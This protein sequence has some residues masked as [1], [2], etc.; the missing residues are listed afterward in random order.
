M[1]L[2]EWD[3]TDDE[4]AEIMAW[5]PGRITQI[6]KVYVDR[7]RVVVALENWELQYRL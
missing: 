6:R 1:L 2:T 5:S 3:L 4:A 7:T